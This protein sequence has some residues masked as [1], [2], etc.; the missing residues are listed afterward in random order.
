MRMQHFWRTARVTALG[1][2]VAA[3]GV[4]AT[5]PASALDEVTIA[6]A[7]TAV[8]R[9]PLYVAI[10]NDYF[11]D[12]GLK[13]TV[14]NTRSGSDGMKMLAGGAVNFDVGQLVD[15]VNLNKQG[16]NARGIAQ[17]TNR[18]T[19]SIIVRKDLADEIKSL[20]DL[21]RRPLGV[22]GIG[23]GTWQ[24]A[25]FIATQEGLKRED[26]NIIGVGTGANVVGAIKSKRVAAMSYAEPETLLLTKEGDAE[27][28]VD[29]GDPATHAKFIG[30]DYMSNWI[31][32]LPSYAREHKQNVQAF[33]NAIQLGLNWLQGRDPNEVAALLKKVSGFDRMDESILVAS[34][35]RQ[36]V[37]KTA[38]V[39]QAAFDNALKIPLTVGALKEKMP[40]SQLVDNSYAE[41]AAKALATKP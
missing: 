19:N 1:A 3:T 11:A 35:K 33:V 38:V 39:S 5:T 9:L 20:K 23:S 22:T 15:A 6:H 40:F 4:S 31:M 12:Q 27:M 7:G 14:V 2:V 34:V 37:P 16:I 24:F 8:F 41:A 18:F 13:L 10:V 29:M 21:K 26:L 30:N 17:L 36:S 32:V 28:L 25:M